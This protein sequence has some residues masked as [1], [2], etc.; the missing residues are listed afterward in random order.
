MRSGILTSLLILLVLTGVLAYFAGGFVA[1]AVWCEGC[2]G[3]LG[4]T[5]GRVFIG[6]VV[7]VLSA[8]SFGFPPKDAG[9]ATRLN[10][11]P[12]I[13]GCWAVFFLAALLWACFQGESRKS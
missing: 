11:W 6:L 2:S 7:C 5:L 4:N 3:L 12:F 1:G 10:T 9:G 8:V 13:L